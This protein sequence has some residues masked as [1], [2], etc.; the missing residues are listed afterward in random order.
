MYV[1]LTRRRLETRTH[2]YMLKSKN[3][4]V[5]DHIVNY[6]LPITTYIE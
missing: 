4:R 1:P 2:I 6:N 5:H 3:T